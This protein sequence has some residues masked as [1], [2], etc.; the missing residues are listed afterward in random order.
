MIHLNPDH[1]LQT[2][3]GRVFT[4]ERN[5]AAWE[6]LYCDLAHFLYSAH[7]ASDLFIV[8]GVQG[9]GKSTWIKKHGKR[10]GGNAIF[11]DAALPGVRHR[12]RILSLAKDTGTSVK[13]VWMDVPLEIALYR[14]RQRILEEQV[15]QDVIEYVFF[16]FEPPT[17]VEGFA[18]I[19]VVREMDSNIAAPI[20]EPQE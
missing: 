1:Y 20:H 12:A 14:N 11:V 4:P 19:I 7:G 8:L 16:H 15:P 3:N 13:A 18:E 17:L 9:S 2:E 5:V 10:F 6:K